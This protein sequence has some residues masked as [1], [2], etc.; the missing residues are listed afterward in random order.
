MV[1]GLYGKT[2]VKRTQPAEL[3]PNTIRVISGAL[4][5]CPNAADSETVMQDNSKAFISRYA[6][7]RDYHKVMRINCKNS[8][9]KFNRKYIN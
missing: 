1:N 2:R 9:K 7:G 5:Y 8:V 3:V 4:D 6:L